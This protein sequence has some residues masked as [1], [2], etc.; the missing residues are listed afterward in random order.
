MVDRR[1]PC[2]DRPL[3][4][5]QPPL[6]RRCEAAARPFRRGEERR[7]CRRTGVLY[8][9][10]STRPQSGSLVCAGDRRTGLHGVY[11]PGNG[12]PDPRGGWWDLGR[13]H[14]WRRCPRATSRAEPLLDYVWGLPHSESEFVTVVVPELFDEP[15]LKDAVLRRRSTFAAQAPAAERARGR[16]YRRS[17]DCRSGCSAGAPSRCRVLLSGVQAAS[18][19]AVNYARSLG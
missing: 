10:T 4:A 14:P 7:Q 16:C 5:G 9:E 6:P 19:R 13:R 1:R 3:S 15:S 8:V 18:L 2:A 17:G 12:R 11:V